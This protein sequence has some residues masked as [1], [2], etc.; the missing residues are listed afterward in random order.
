MLTP[1]EIAQ[2]VIKGETTIDEWG[3]KVDRETYMSARIEYIKQMKIKRAA[4]GKPVQ[5]VVN[6]KLQPTDPVRSMKMKEAWAR[7]KAAK[8]VIQ[9]ETI[10]GTPVAPKIYCEA[11]PLTD[12]ID[13]QIQKHSKILEALYLLKESI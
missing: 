12:L 11:S 3:L 8:P 9:K 10:V 6:G 7:R 1:S 13:E 4:E 5:N 2:S